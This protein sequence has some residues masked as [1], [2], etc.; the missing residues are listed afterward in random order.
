MN[1]EALKLGTKCRSPKGIPRHTKGSKEVDDGLEAV[2][3]RGI[4]EFEVSQ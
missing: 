3:Y 1:L 2:K 4:P